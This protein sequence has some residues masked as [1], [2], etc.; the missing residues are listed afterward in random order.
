MPKPVKSKELHTFLGL[1]K[2]SAIYVDYN[3]M[4]KRLNLYALRLSGSDF[5]V[6]KHNI[7]N[8]APLTSVSAFCQLLLCLWT[9]HLSYHCVSCIMGCIDS[10]QPWGHFL[11]PYFSQNWVCPNVINTKGQFTSS[12]HENAPS[13]SVLSTEKQ[14][15][16]L[17]MILWRWSNMFHRKEH[18]QA[19]CR[20]EHQA[21]MYSL[22]SEYF[23]YSQT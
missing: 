14:M 18:A 1:H 9:H 12:P 4:H 10:R 22:H 8:P 2:V 11:P 19:L 7:N 16:L 3:K 17:L 5:T 15:M 13:V 20:V 6:M 23:T 21:T